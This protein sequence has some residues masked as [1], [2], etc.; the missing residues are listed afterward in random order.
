[1]NNTVIIKALTDYGFS[2]FKA[3]EIALDYRRG[4]NYAKAV[5]DMAL[6]R[7]E[8]TEEY[9]YEIEP[10]DPN[11]SGDPAGAPVV[12]SLQ[13][14]TWI[15]PIHHRGGIAWTMSRSSNGPAVWIGETLEAAQATLVKWVEQFG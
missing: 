12:S 10:N 2:A 6:K 8:L 1:M 3:H 11:K 5:V 14:G 13:G 7:V 4:N 9:P 15:R